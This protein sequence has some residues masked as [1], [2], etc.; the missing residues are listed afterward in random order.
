MVTMWSE[1]TMATLEYYPVGV[2][3]S[4]V[5]MWSHWKLVTLEYCPVDVVSSYG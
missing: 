1:L 5:R 3:P 4:V 2:A